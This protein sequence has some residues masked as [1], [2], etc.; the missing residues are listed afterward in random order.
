MAND[1]IIQ[2]DER[3]LIIRANQAAE[4]AAQHFIFEEYKRIRP[5]AT[6]R[7]QRNDLRA[8]A[9]FLAS[10][11]IIPDEQVDD[12]AKQL[13]VNSDTW[14]GI[15]YGLVKAFCEWLF[16]EGYAMGTINVRLATVKRYC[17]LAFSSGTIA[18]DEYT[19]IQTV[20]W[21]KAADAGELDATRTVKRVGS[22]KPS[23]T[24]IGTDDA[25]ALRIALD[26]PEGHRDSFIMHILLGYGLRCGEL[27]LITRQNIDTKLGTILFYRPKIKIWQTIQINTVTRKALRL[28]L[29]SVGVTSDRLLVRFKDGLPTNKPMSSRDI[30]RVVGMMGAM[31]GL[32]TLSPHDCRHYWAT[33]AA[34]NKTPID[35]L[36]QAGGWASLSMPARYIQDASIANEGVINDT[37][38]PKKD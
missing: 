32:G 1:I 33:N 7:R 16:G 23:N 5:A 9:T 3:S 30:N 38:T 13:Y 21:Y 8:F 27:E 10:Y 6:L 34:R 24:I 20:K 15:G 18:A 19:K 36:K 2:T 4:H 17:Q 11:Q 22:K 26:K 28:Y 25:H 12:F 31:I 29:K 35:R 14:R 37:D